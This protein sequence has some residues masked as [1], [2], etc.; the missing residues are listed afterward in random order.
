MKLN[1]V[2]ARDI[3]PNVYTSVLPIKI[4]VKGHRDMKKAKQVKYIVIVDF[5]GYKQ[6]I[7]TPLILRQAQYK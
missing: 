7:V 6:V 5:Q 2:A 3:V 4:R 1:K